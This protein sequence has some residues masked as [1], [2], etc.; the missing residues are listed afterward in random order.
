MLGRP[1]PGLRSSAIGGEEDF[2]AFEAEGWSAQA[3]SY[4]RLMGRVTDR[5]AGALLD[6]V[7]VGAGDRVLDVATGTGAVA[8]A[9]VARGAEVTG[10]DISEEMLEVARERVPSGHFMSADAEELELG[11]E[12]FDAGVAGF[13]INHLPDPERAV[14]AWT[15][16]LRP[17]G[18][19]SLSVWNRPE[20]NRFF[21]LIGDAMAE[22]EAD[23]TVPPGPDP[24][25]FADP[26]EMTALLDGAGLRES[27]TTR[28]DF[29]QRVEDVEHLW[30]GM[31]GGSVRSAARVEAQPE[32]DRRRVRRTL[33][34]LAEV[35]REGDHLA[36]PV[37]VRL[38][39]A[40]RA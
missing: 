35:H 14:A 26:V 28:L 38:G 9:A 21:G 8:A 30:Q 1:T 18:R 33:E 17:G 32:A 22:T 10:V 25:R 3:D 23:D 2:K 6:A 29:E 5:V 15:R 24:Y 37:S 12:R 27:R 16:A 19:L 4:D 34:R 20:E 31:L 11:E 39:S 13:L 36:V 7:S 40:V